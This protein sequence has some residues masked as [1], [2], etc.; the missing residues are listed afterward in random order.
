[1]FD[2]VVCTLTNVK[3]ILKMKNLVSLGVLDTNGHQWLVA[4]GVLQVKSR[5]R[6][7]LKGN[8]HRNLYVL[9]GNTVCREVNITRS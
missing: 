4:N 8:K 9:E 6:V 5:N 7:I 3:Y 1:M 2:G